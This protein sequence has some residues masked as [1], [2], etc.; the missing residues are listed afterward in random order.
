MSGRK[1]TMSGLES[2]VEAEGK[3]LKRRLKDDIKKLEDKKK[4]FKRKLDDL[5]TEQEN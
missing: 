3:Q 5:S 1:E 4:Q 2:N